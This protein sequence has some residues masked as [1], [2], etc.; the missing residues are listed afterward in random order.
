MNVK[1]NV[2][3]L[4]L[5]WIWVWAVATPVLCNGGEVK[6]TIYYSSRTALVREPFPI[7]LEI[8]N[9]TNRKQTVFADLTWI[10]RES[11][12]PD[13]AQFEPAASKS[14]SE[15]EMGDKPHLV[16]RSLIPVGEEKKHVAS[17]KVA[18]D[19]NL[20][21]IAPGRSVLL[22]IELPPE[23]FGVG[24]CSLEMMIRKGKE[25]IARSASVTITGVRKKVEKTPEQ[26]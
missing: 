20:V 17:P 16:I 26:K 21:E 22:K 12:V 19:R 7:I 3:L 24:E 5:I 8:Q 9:D 14:T 23:C 25:D 4:S 10:E 1:K 13:G 15:S 2:S 6:L 11:L 18:V